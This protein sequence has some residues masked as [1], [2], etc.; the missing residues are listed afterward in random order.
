[1]KNF[2]RFAS[3]V[4]VIMMMLSVMIPAMAG[5][6]NVP[7]SKDDDTNATNE[8]YTAYKIFDVSKLYTTSEDENGDEVQTESGWAY[9]IASGNA[10]VDVLKK[11]EQT[12][13]TL[14]LSADGSKYIIEAADTFTDEA[15]AK[16]F[17]A[18][19]LENKPETVTGTVL[20]EGSN[21]V[22]DGYYLITSSLGS[23]LALTTT[24][25]SVD[26][27][28]KNT[29]PTLTKTVSDNEAQIGDTVVY[30]ITVTVPATVDKALTVH[31]TIENG[32]TIDT[33]SFAVKVDETALTKDSDYTVTT[34][35]E[36]GCSFEIVLNTTDAVKGKTVVIT[37]E[38][39]LD[40]DAEIANDTNDNNA[41]LTYSNY[42]TPT[43]TVSVS[44]YQAAVIKV[45]TGTST[46]IEGAEFSLYTVKEDGTPVVLVDITAEGASE[47]T[48]RVADSTETTGTTTTIV[49]GKAVIQ[50]LD[51][52]VTYYLEET[53]A[54]SGYNMLNARAELKVTAE[55]E[56]GA[57][58][59]INI[60]NSTGTELP[61]T[62]GIGTTI[63]YCIG[64]VL[65]VGA[66]VLLITKKRMSREM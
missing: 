24:D 16:A 46:Q 4:M 12:W 40:K 39:E 8:T 65:A 62:G 7:E 9:S 55:D 61:S 17:A 2:K 52:D 20:S 18:W 5:A 59:S 27:T 23:A 32:L 26:I 38:A 11:V 43:S 45:I 60:E 29:Y 28:E 35:C 42:K 33:E 50:G 36:D 14:T 21:D 66:F 48:Y 15:G 10:W 37:Y 34:S 25:V 41:Y 47:K 51:S 54:P 64:A 57:N 13:V 22:G 63:F 31:D 3:V 19:L 1:M 49:A 6:I 58:V 44:T 30:T 56:T 53:K